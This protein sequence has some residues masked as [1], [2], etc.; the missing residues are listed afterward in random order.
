MPKPTPSSF[1]NMRLFFTEDGLV[2]VRLTG[3]SIAII[4][5]E[6]IFTTIWSAVFFNAIRLA[7]KSPMW[8]IVAVLPIL[9]LV[10]WFCLRSMGMLTPAAK[11]LLD[12]RTRVIYPKGR[13]KSSLESSRY[14]ISGGIPFTN[15]VC[16]RVTEEY[17]F[18]KQSFY[19]YCLELVLGNGESLYLLNH[20][21]KEILMDEARKLAA[22]TGFSLQTFDES[23][24]PHLPQDA[25]S[26]QTERIPAAPQTASR[27]PTFLFGAFF[28][29]VSLVISFFILLRPMGTW[30]ASRNWVQTEA[31]ILSSN[32]A[33]SSSKGKATYR[34]NITFRYEYNGHSYTGNKYDIFRSST[35]SNI[36]VDEMRRVV[37]S[38]HPGEQVTC[39]V[40]PQKPFQAI[41]TRDI[42]LPLL[43]FICCFAIGFPGAGFTILY[44]A[45]K[46]KKKAR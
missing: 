1:R 12:L 2:R 23:H 7:T 8:A 38:H 28:T 30:F 18:R 37:D 27:V 31:V 40:N 9:Y 35:A 25:P 14:D 21:K 10:N 36:G 5:V 6:F 44:F 39:L 16:L 32:L 34:I 17:V 41:I 3:I 20:A 22:A 11:I 4:V 46:G 15:V 43:L 26:V 42:Y 29:L 19:A 33:R 13:D 45:F 24:S